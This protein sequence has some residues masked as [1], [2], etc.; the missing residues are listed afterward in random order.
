MHYG[1]LLIAGIYGSEVQI[2]LFAISK[3]AVSAT[4][5]SILVLFRWKINSEK[6]TLKVLES[7]QSIV[8]N[9]QFNS[10]FSHK[11]IIFTSILQKAT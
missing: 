6:M 7:G 2:W 5:S 11:N 8:Y 10:L 3:M 4:F 9:K 1:K